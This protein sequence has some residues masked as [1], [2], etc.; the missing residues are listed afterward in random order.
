MEPD[1]N[2]QPSGYDNQNSYRLRDGRLGTESRLSFEGFEAMKPE[3]RYGHQHEANRKGQFS[4]A[5]RDSGN[6]AACDRDP[7]EK[8][9]KTPA[10]LSGCCH[11]NSSIGEISWLVF[12]LSNLR[13]DRRRQDSGG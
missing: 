5:A 9:A 11:L 7:Y 10:L 13:K 12:T 1:K 3:E 2:E 8:Q 6:P 4:Q